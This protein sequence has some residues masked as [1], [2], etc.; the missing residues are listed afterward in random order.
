[1][2]AESGILHVGES[3]SLGPGGVNKK[4]KQTASLRDHDGMRLISRWYYRRLFL[5]PKLL[6]PPRS[7]N[8]SGGSSGGGGGAGGGLSL[9]P[10]TF[11]PNLNWPSIGDLRD[12]N[13]RS[14]F[15]SFGFKLDAPLNPH[16]TLP[17]TPKD[18]GGPDP[19]GPNP[20]PQGP[21]CNREPSHDPGFTSCQ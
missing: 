20:K 16:F 1:V 15:D 9:G 12:W 5:D 2:V 10:F 13:P 8:S 21:Q 4:E 11:K 3:E 18:S 17:A 7:A 19:N 14:L 6:P